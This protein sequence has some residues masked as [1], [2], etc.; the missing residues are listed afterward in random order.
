MYYSIL[1]LGGQRM[2]TVKAM[3]ESFKTETMLKV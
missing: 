1:Y 3:Q 2:P